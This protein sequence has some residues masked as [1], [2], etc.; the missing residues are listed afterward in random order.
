MNRTYD[1]DPQLVSRL[2]AVAKARGLWQS[3]LAEYCLAY[4]LDAIEAGALPVPVIPRG[5]QIQRT[6]A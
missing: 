5:Y 3:D 6:P 2:D 4:A 1:L